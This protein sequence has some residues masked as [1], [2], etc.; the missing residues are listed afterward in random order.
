MTAASPRTVGALGL[1]GGHSPS[2]VAACGG[3]PIAADRHVADRATPS[4]A[5]VT[6]A[7]EHRSR[8]RRCAYP[9]ERRRAVRP[10]GGARTPTHGPYTG[11]LKRI[12]RDRRRRPSCSSCARPDV[13]FLSKI[14]FAA[15][16]INDTAWLESHIDPADDRPAGD[17]R[18]R[19]TAPARTGSRAGTAARTSAWPATTATGATPA[20]RAADRPLERRRRRSGSSSS[21]PATVDGID[22]V[23]PTGFEAVEADSDLQLAPRAGLERLLR[24]LQQHLRAVRQRAGPPGDRHGHRP[25]AHRRRPST[26]PARRSPTHFTPCAIPHGC[27]GDAWYEFDPT[28]AKEMLAAAGFPDGFETTIQYRDDADATTCPTRPASRPS[29]RPSC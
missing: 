7:A 8:S 25:P 17:R 28:L 24:R 16:A 21:R 3:R 4:R 1:P 10:G 6:A 29:S 18:P 22:D 12:T 23:G 14:A 5:P 13:A 15:F 9:A 2:P 26:R 27:A 19:S 20:Q 11:D